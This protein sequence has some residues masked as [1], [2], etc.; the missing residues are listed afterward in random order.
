MHAFVIHELWQGGSTVGLFEGWPI[1][2]VAMAIFL[3]RVADVS[4]GTVR[5][6]CV[7]QGKLVLSVVLGFFEVLIW[8]FGAS[9]VIA[10]IRTHPQLALAFAAGFAAGNGVGIL[11]ERA[12]ALGSVALTII[13]P[14]EGLQ[15]AA[16]LRARGQRLT[17][18]EGEGRDGAV[19][20]LYTT[21]PRRELR[22]LL[23]QARAIDPRLFYTV[24]PLR[25][26][27]LDS[28]Q[29]SRPHAPGWLP[30]VRRRTAAG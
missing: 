15:I 9:H 13:S 21:C 24:E 19:T 8:L 11:V 18:F 29:V 2:A 30:L 23:D 7:V 5:T 26:W 12:V 22:T 20:M 1:W 17:T 4:L 25:E 14:L 28:S 16:S 6:I 3:L 10:T 27:R